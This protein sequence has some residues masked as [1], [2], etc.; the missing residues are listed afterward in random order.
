MARAYYY[1]FYRLYVFVKWMRVK[2][3]KWTAMLLVA[4]LMYFNLAT[5]VYRIFPIEKVIVHSV[6]ST[7][8]I[9][10]VPLIAINYYVLLAKGKSGKTITLFENESRTRKVV[11]SL[12]TLVYVVVT[13]VLSTY[14]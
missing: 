14:S 6:W 8:V 10:S 11:S 2:D 4:S 7:A 9:I 1:L 3:A 13:L 12:L 5:I